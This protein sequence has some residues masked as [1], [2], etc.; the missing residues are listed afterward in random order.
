MEGKTMQRRTLVKAL[1]SAPTAGLIATASWAQSYPSK[2][3]RVIVPF[4]PG[5]STDTSAR[6]VAEGLTRLFG[7]QVIVENKPGGR[8]IIGT[9]VVAKAPADG[10]TI[11][12]AP[13][14]FSTNVAFDDTLP[15]DTAK[16]F[17]PIVRTVDMPMLFSCSMEAPYRTVAELL[18]WAKTAKPPIPYAAVGTGSSVHLWGEMIRLRTGM[19]MEHISYKGS[20]DALRDVMGGIVPLF[21][22]VIVP[23]AAMVSAGRLRG[24]AI[25]TRERFRMLPDV[26]T[27]AEAGLP[28]LEATTPFGLVAPAGTPAETVAR[29]NAGVNEVFKDAAM[30]Q[31]LLDLGFLPI[32]GT[33]AEYAAFLDSEIVRW[34]KVIQEAKVPKPA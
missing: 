16:D 22:D 25:G 34:R 14:T 28:G 1:A 6:I 2:P 10:Y 18:A 21:T 17:V 24:L 23:G 9:E 15:Y 30:R 20:S 7:Q 32:G 11:L 29:L 26:P 19:P 31:K 13:A 27:M 33:P 4:T 5:G 8:T 12:Y 3:I